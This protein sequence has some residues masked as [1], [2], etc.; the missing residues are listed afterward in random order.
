MSIRQTK[1]TEMDDGFEIEVGSCAGELLVEDWGSD[2]KTAE[3]DFAN[4]LSRLK[5]LVSDV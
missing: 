3:Q 5:A 2:S 1:I 4:A